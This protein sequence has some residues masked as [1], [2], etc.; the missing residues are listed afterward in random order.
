MILICYRPVSAAWDFMNPDRKCIHLQAFFVYMSTANRVL[1]LFV[2]F[3][4]V[5]YLLALKTVPRTIR[6]ALIACFG[7]GVL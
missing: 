7:Y 6:A 1:D 2:F 5:C 3:W 4:P